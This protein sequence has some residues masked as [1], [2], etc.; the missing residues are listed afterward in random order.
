MKREITSAS[1]F[2]ACI[3]IVLFLSYTSLYSQSSSMAPTNWLN[4]YS[5][6]LRITPEQ[7]ETIQDLQDKFLKET[8]STQNKLNSY[9]L[10]LQTMPG[11]PTA[12]DAEII[13]KQNEIVAIQQELQEKAQKY[14][15]EAKAVL[16]LE[17]IS[18]LP[19][20][21]TMGF[22]LGRGYGIGRGFGRGISGGYGRGMGGGF[23]RGI[24]GGFGRGMSRGYGRGMGRG[25]GRRGF[26][27]GMN[28]GFGRGL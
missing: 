2:L 8:A 20:G 4:T 25:F 21:C 18:L 24:G 23:G 16:T 9:Y 26:G 3:I 5:D 14:G 28:R 11:Q 17:Q 22:I 27:R 10:A 7:S 13:A 19:P 15:L 1:V 6:Y 12:D